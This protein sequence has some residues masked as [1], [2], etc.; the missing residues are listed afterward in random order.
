M[1]VFLAFLEQKISLLPIIIYISI[2]AILD[3][4]GT[5]FSSDSAI[6][7][8]WLEIMQ[9]HEHLYE[10]M[11]QNWEK[12]KFWLLIYRQKLNITLLISEFLTKF[13]PLN[14]YQKHAF[15]MKNFEKILQF[16]RF[17]QILSNSKLLKPMDIFIY[18]HLI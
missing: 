16:C 11:A 7:L 5:W 3:L 12:S 4:L 1:G 13:L 17:D 2:D 14:H 9:I 15:S 18:P 8:I 10:N 6:S